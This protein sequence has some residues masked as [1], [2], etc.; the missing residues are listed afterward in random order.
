MRHRIDVSLQSKV[1]LK[2]I[3]DKLEIANLSVSTV[4]EMCIQAVYDN[5]ENGGLV[6]EE[7]MNP[8]QH[9]L[10]EII[11]MLEQALPEV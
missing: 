7:R 4:A 8:T 2:S 9:K 11:Y 1:M 10:D 5:L 3:A 6:F